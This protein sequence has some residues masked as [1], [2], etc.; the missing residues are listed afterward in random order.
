MFLWYDIFRLSACGGR[1]RPVHPASICI[2]SSYISFFCGA[3]TQERL[4]VY[5]A[6]LFGNRSPLYIHTAHIPA[7]PP[8]LSHEAVFALAAAAPS[9]PHAAFSCSISCALLDRPRL[10]GD[11]AG[12]AR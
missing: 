9:R 3:T 12:E 11:D 7:P 1:A 6:R 8:P 2:L 4:P 10:S 5:A